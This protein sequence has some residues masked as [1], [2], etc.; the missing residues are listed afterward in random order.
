MRTFLPRLS[1]S[2]LALL[3][4]SVARAGADDS[5]WLS[6]YKADLAAAKTSNKKVLMD[7]T[8]SDWC[9]WCIKMDKEVLDTDQFKAY[10][11]KILVLMLVDFPQSKQLPQAV[12][13]QNAGLQK[14]YAVEGFPTFILLDKNGKVLGTQTGYLDGGPSAFI[15][16][17][18]SQK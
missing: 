9:P 13:D 2:I 12:Q 1:L 14:T 8:G 16:W 6:D 5:A 18:E 10:A 4:L 7:F 3:L 15:A 17:V 11:G